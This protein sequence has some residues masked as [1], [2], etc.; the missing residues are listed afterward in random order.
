MKQA[1]SR[2]YVAVDKNGVIL[3]QFNGAI[4]NAISNNQI[5]DL[6]KNLAWLGFSL[7][8]IKITEIK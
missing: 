3:H 4:Y 6:S 5:Y 1:L 7:Q 2:G 8:E